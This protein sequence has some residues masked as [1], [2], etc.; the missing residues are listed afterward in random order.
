MSDACLIYRISIWGPRALH[1]LLIFVLLAGCTVGPDFAPLTPPEVPVVPPPIHVGKAADRCDPSDKA[2]RFCSPQ[3]LVNGRDVPGEWWR[4]FHSKAL[5]S[6]MERAL[7]ENHD[8]KAAQ[9]ALRGAHASYEAQRGALFPVVDANY[10]PSKQKVAS[11]DFSAPTWSLLPYYTLH[12]AQ[13]TVSYVPDVFGGVR[14]QIEAAG[15]REDLQR[16]MLEATYLTLTSNIALAAI[17][18]ASLR[19][20]IK[21]TDK[22][23]KEE[24]PSEELGSE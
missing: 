18:E 5:N 9:A 23:I 24:K 16:F 12:T 3:P 10:L 1:S 8:L 11:L 22:A 20:Q 2:A 17:Q 6:V 13:L 19:E 15:A 7:W 14:R 4:L 21:V